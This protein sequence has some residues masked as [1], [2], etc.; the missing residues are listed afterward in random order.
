[1][2]ARYLADKSALARLTHPAVASWLEPRILDGAVARCSIIDMELLFSAR[3]YAD[4]VSIREDRFAGF[5]LVE[6]TQLD[7]DRS[8]EVMQALAKAGKHRA[9]SIP[10]LIIAAVAER[11]GMTVVHYDHD[12][13]HI[14]GITIQSMHWV[15]PK[16]SL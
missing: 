16:G 11:V 8:V 1:L 2:N 13:D 9:V 3:N 14:A 15:A 7:F 5:Q 10:D 6:T 12:F 4:L